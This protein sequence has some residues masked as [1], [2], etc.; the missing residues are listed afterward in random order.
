MK[1]FLFN[2]ECTDGGRGF[3]G[4]TGAK[5]RMTAEGDT[6]EE[7]EKFI[8]LNIPGGWIYKCVGET[9]E[10]FYLEHLK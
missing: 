3:W 2:L 10:D 1:R 7:A 8:K 9:N 6:P 5:A 4:K